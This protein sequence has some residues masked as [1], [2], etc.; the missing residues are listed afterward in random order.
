MDMIQAYLLSYYVLI[1]YAGDADHGPLQAPMTYTRGR[2]L[3][4]GESSTRKLT[5]DVNEHCK[6]SAGLPFRSVV[7]RGQVVWV[8]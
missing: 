3:L 4:N 1:A 6:S 5:S 2:S 7:I 8:I